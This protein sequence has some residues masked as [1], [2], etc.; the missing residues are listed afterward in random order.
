VYGD[1]VAGYAA[2]C[3]ANEARNAHPRYV[4]RASR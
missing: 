3:K 4:F 1:L 2:R